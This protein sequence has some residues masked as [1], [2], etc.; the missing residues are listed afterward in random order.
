MLRKIMLTVVVV[1]VVVALAGAFWVYR[2]VYAPNVTAPPEGEKYH[3]VYIRTGWGY[4]QVLQMLTE[5]NIIINKTGFDKIA[6]QMNYPQKV[7]PGRYLVEGGMSNRALALLLRSGKQTP[8][9]IAIHNIRTK[10]D[11]VQ[12]ICSKL[13]TDSIELTRMLND[14][15]YLAQH[16]L[17]PQNVIGM[18]IADTYRFNWNTDAETFFKRMKREYDN[19][20]TDERIQKARLN[21]L[22]PFEAITLASIVEEETAQNDE[23][24]QIAGVYYNRLSANMPLQADPTVKFAVGDFSLKRILTEHLAIESPY[25]TYKYTGLPPGPIRI[26]SLT[27]LQAVLNPTEH[28]YLYF[29]AKEDFSGYHNFAVTYEEHL[30]NARKYRDEL[31]RRNIK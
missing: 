2:A 21:G 14:T 5:K 9:D 1:F 7:Y 30:I 18:F 20:W 8:Y 11:L 31:N 27:A 28:S 17:T 23:M 16:N 12:L 6:R 22:T 26:P 3:Q 19:F 13:E 15:A 25:N 24:N 10:P 4:E 29:C